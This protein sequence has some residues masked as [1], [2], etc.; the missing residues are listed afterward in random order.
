MFDIG[1][2]ELVKYLLK[3]YPCEGY[4]NTEEKFQDFKKNEKMF[5]KKL[6]SAYRKAQKFLIEFNEDEQ[7]IN[8]NF[9]DISIIILEFINNMINREQNGI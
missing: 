5:L 1:N 8:E 2:E 7:N 9:K 4:Q 3:N 6:N